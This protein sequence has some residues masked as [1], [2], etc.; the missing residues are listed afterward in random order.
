[1]MRKAGRIPRMGVYDQIKAAI[2]DLVAPAIHEINGKLSVLDERVTALDH[3]MD[4]K[5]SLVEVKID[6]LRTEMSAMKNELTAELR[7]VD[8]RLDGLDRELRFAIDV[9]ERIAAL[10]ARRTP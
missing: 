5:I 1:M 2:Q 10:E 9:R 3:K 7:R 8:G 6:A 4:Q